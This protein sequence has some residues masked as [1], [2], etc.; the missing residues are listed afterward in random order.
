M[1]ERFITPSKITAWLDCAHFLALKHQV[2]DGLREAPTG[3]MG[4]FARLLADKGMQHEAA[5][6]D[7]YEREGKSIFRVPERGKRESFGNWV[8]RV[9]DPFDQDWDVIYQMPFAHDGIRGIA[10]FLVRVVD[11]E[12]GTTYE[13]VDAKLARKEAKTGH[14]L[15][16]CFYADAIEAS[17]GRRPARMHLW[18]GSGTQETFAVEDFGAYWR[19]LRRQLSAVM[20]API[21]TIGTKPEPCNHCAFCEFAD[22]CDAQWRDE[23]SL[24]YVAG[25][26]SSERTPLEDCGVSSLVELA[27]RTTPVEGVGQERQSRL[28]VQAQL[29]SLARENGAGAP[30]FLL[31]EGGEDPTWGHGFDQLPAPDTGSA[32]RLPSIGGLQLA[33]HRRA[34]APFRLLLPAPPE[35]QAIPVRGS[36]VGERGV[37]RGQ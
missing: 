9:G 4:S 29:Q 26:R 33:P 1:T 5:C 30:P 18:L 22:V 37:N 25:L 31:I 20:D 27:E 12:A 17:T 8:E 10:D 34:R 32:R 23:D 15:Q 19:R 2:E 21:G 24:I 3:G 13:P 11:A 14:V 16:L 7:E 28:V 6:L 36:P 35:P